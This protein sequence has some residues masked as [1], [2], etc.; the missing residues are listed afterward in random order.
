MFVT[1]ET[2]RADQNIQPLSYDVRLPEEAQ[3]D[4]LRLLDASRAV[5]NA[6][7]ARLW[8]RLDE[9]MGERSGP[10]WKQV[11]A[12]TESPDPHGDR[13]FRCES[14][15]T[16]RI[17]RAQAARK[18]VF[19]L[20]HPIL[21][22]GFIRPKDGKRP[23]GKN[24]KQI[25]EGIRALQHQLDDDET[26]FVS[27]QNVVEQACNHFLSHGSFPTCYEEMQAVPLLKVG[28]LTY[29]GDDGGV[30]GQS[31]RLS[32]DLHAQTACLRF[33][34]P[35]AAG[36][37]QWRQD[38][39]LL[40]LPACVVERLKAGKPMAPTL[41]ELVKPDGGR[42]AVLDVI[43]QEKCA[44]LADWSQVERVLGFDWGVNTLLTATVLQHNP[45]DPEHPLQV[46]RPFFLN[47][48]GLDGHQARTRRQIDQLK[49]VRD[50]LAAD[51]PKRAVY[52][53]EIR[54]C[55]RLYEARNHELAHL[56]ANLLLL[57]ARVWGCQAICGERLST[58]KSTGRGRGVRGRWRNWRNN[59]TIR[60]EIW[61][62]LRYKCHL[63]GIRF[64]SETPDG[65]SHTC[66]HCGEPART[67]RSP[68]PK[69]RAEPVKWGRWLCCPQCGFN[70][71]RD[72]CAALNIARLG[73]AFLTS[74]QRTG[75]GESFS[76]TEIVS[77]K[78][79][80]YMAHDAVALFPPHT[81]PHRLMDSGKLYINGWK[82]SVTLRSS[83]ATPVLLGL[84]S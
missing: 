76:V 81:D 41:R 58:L 20:I 12:M 38:G 32:F 55:W 72:Y 84:C 15:T 27:L 59:T 70:G 7:L 18:Q 67:F 9:F 34:F 52:Q 51:D 66:P 19:A 47:T 33:R 11:V 73:I 43:V 28:L 36:R 63:L 71:D 56:A 13:Q 31:Y 53:E 1:G 83:Y 74:M 42:A 64:R 49:V 17:L 3:A 16:G 23:A 68:R 82:K 10:A 80:P 78:P 54:R 37:W 6:L 44:P 65:T 40:P 77:V 29:A 25:T 2:M 26:A 46:S 14:E 69:H 75:Q 50:R 48:A 8:P 22:D 62:I 35:D 5:V 79:C 39:V 21:C 57:F 45:A 61:R 60:A 4:A 30:L 24:R